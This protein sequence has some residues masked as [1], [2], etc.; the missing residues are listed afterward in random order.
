MKFDKIRLS[1]FNNVDLPILDA[2]PSGAYILK[3]ADGLGPPVVDV[4]I[5]NTLLSGGVYQGRRPQN[6]EI[7]LL[8]GLNPAW[9]ANQTAEQLRTTIYTMLTPRS[10]TTLKLQLMSGNTVVAQAE[11]YISKFEISVFS[12]DPEVQITITCLQPYLMSPE[13]GFQSPYKSVSGGYTLFTVDNI[14]TAPSGFNLSIAFTAVHSG[15]F[16]ILEN[17]SFPQFMS[18][19]GGFIAGDRLTVDTRAGQRGVWKTPNG[20]QVAVSILDSLTPESPWLQLYGGANSLKI[21]NTTFNWNLFGI[22]HTP[23]YWGV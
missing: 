19:N 11:G 23:A 8:V 3:S 1:G 6:R 9:G 12:K 5:A 20:S 10:G 13:I 22:A 2:S 18:I 21:N 4:S 17:T 14:G 7:V 16:Q 15:T